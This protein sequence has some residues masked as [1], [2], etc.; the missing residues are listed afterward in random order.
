MKQLIIRWTTTH[1]EE[2]KDDETGDPYKFPIIESHVQ[3]FL[4]ED[5]LIID[6]KWSAI[7]VTLLDGERVEIKGDNIA[8]FFR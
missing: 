6:H 3:S 4:L 1:Y 5:V 2:R 8:Q 7:E